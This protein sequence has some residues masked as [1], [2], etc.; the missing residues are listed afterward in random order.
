VQ[1]YVNGQLRQNSTTDELIFSIANLI[2][3]ISEGQTIQPGDVIATGTPAGVGFGQKPPIFLK[4]GDV[5][6][7]SV[8]G[9]GVLKNTISEPSAKNQTIVRVANESH[10]P[11]SNLTKTCGG[12]GLTSLNSKQLYYF[13]AGVS[14]GS[15]IIFI[16]GLGGSSEF[17]TPL[18]SNLGLEKTHSLH[19]LDL[20][21]HGLSATSATSKISIES[22]AADF[23]AL[24]QHANISGATVVAHSMGCLIGLTLAL[25]N[26]ELVSKLV[27]L[28]P[29]PSPVPEA[30]RNGSIARAAAVRG[31]G[32]AS[33]VDAVVTAGTSSKSKTD[34][35]VGI[36]AVRLSLLSQDPEGYA[37]GCTALAGASE[38]L[39]VSQIKAQTLIVTGDED[40]VSPAQVCEK[41]AGEIKGAKVKVLAGVGHWHIF[42]DVKGVAGAVSSFI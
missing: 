27:L 18:I 22:Y 7:V 13:Q 1:T 24:A 38:A 8:T 6:E 35:A 34:N 15:P 40:K 19:L 33:V 21:G 20:E 30:G 26:P 37:K 16:H 2:K 17:Y 29:P 36:V 5:V 11:I 31:G 9:L 39:P 4:P 14:S 32:M 10:I 41:Y 42:E 25:Q 12:V 28:G 3:T 23:A